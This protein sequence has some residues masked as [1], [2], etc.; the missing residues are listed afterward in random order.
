MRFIL[1]SLMV[2]L[3]LG[4]TAQSLQK[5]ETYYDPFSRTRI[6]EAYTT[7]STPPYPIHGVYKEWDPN[8]VLMNEATFKNGKK[9]GA[10]KVYIHSGVAD[11][12]GK[13]SVGKVKTITNYTNDVLNGLDQM[14]DYTY[15]KQ[16]LTFQKT[17]VNGKETKLE[18]WDEKGLKLKEITI[19]GPC[20]ELYKN[21]K[22]KVEY[23]NKDGE[24]DGQ[25]TSWY[26]NGQ[27]EVSTF[28]KSKLENGKHIEYFESGR[29]E[30]EATYVNGK[31]SGAVTLYFE[32]GKTRK[33]RIYDSSTFNLIEEKEYARNGLLKFERQVIGDNIS[34][35]ITYDS[36]SG[37]KL[38]EEGEIYNPQSQ[39]FLRHGRVVQYYPNGKVNIDAAFARNK[40]SG[41]YNEYD[42]DG[43]LI[44]SGEHQDG[45][46]VGEW[47]YYYDA[48]W[49]YA[50]K[51]SDAA[52]YRKI[53]FDPVDG[54][55]ATTDFFITGERQF[56]G[57]LAKVAPD[58]PSGKCTY[59][60]LNGKVSNEVDVDPSGIV[61]SQKMYGEDGKLT[62]EGVSSG[63]A[64]GTG[65]EWIEYFPDGKIKSKGK[66]FENTKVGV[67]TYYDSNGKVTQVQER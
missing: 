60:H 33:L 41:P 51:K 36:T 11:L 25:Y 8:G 19:N 62:R 18:E 38:F 63:A 21:G 15:N 66:T 39:T 53:I 50:A 9:D 32:D 55:W 61:I 23:A 12:Y 24:F 56:V 31:M 16:Q 28:F 49:N 17:W 65:M 3:A 48:D 43:E 27:T 5:V 59:F 57:R 4:A 40:L 52:Y 10:F 7:T 58:I 64:Y 2:A 34:K 44:K 1:P 26:S 14:F 37:V 54:P 22:K 42:I 35:S 30:L 13:A 6:H 45:S 29:P 20:F 46:S 47:L 67:W